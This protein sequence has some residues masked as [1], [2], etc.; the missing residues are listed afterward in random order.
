MACTGKGK[1]YNWGWNDN[2][3]CG[4]DPMYVDEIIVKHSSKFAQVHF[5]GST[6]SYESTNTSTGMKCR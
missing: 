4:K 2:G 3:Q 6:S 5:D 1:M